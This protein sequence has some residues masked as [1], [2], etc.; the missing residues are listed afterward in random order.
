MALAGLAV[1]ACSDEGGD[2]EDDAS[3]TTAASDPATRST[4]STV[5]TIPTD[6]TVSDDLP[7]DSAAAT[8]AMSVDPNPNN[9]LSAIVVVESDEPVSVMLTAVSGDHTVVV[10]QTA[11]V[12]TSHTIPLVGMRSDRTYEV[13]AELVTSDGEI[14]AGADGS[15]ETGSIPERFERYEFSSDPDRSSP[16]YTLIE[17]QRWVD[18]R[19]ITPQ[20]PFDNPQYLIAVDSAGEIVWYYENGPVIGGVEQTPDGTFTSFYWP[21]GVR[22]FDILGNEVG[23]WQVPSKNA[24][25]PADDESSATVP[26]GTTAAGPGID[27]LDPLPVDSDDVVLKLIHHEAIRLDS[28]NYLALSTASHELTPE[29]RRAFCPDDPTEFN[30][31]SDVAVEFEPSGRVVRT[32]DLWD[33]V[34][35]NV[36]P[37]REMCNEFFAVRNDRDWTHANAVIYDEA[38]D[39]V[40]FSARHTS[41]VVAMR[42]SDAE[43]PQT[44]VLW[45]FGEDGS[46]PLEG[47][48]PQYQHAV[49]IE[50]DGSL[51]LYDN[52]NGRAGTSLD[53]PVNPPFSRAVQYEVDDSSDDPAD[54][55]VRQ[56][57]EHRMDDL[58]GEPLFAPF[59][60]DADRVANG[61]V[62]ITHGGID[63]QN[64]MSYL[65]A[66]VVEVVP[67]DASGGDIVWEFRVGSADRLSSIYR[68]ERIESFYVGAEWV[69]D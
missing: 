64:P 25:D 9:V 22:R 46:V 57:W 2:G 38:R 54:W 3:V 6:D 51:L 8:A 43:G 45:I 24:A 27:A 12:A 66:A 19:S 23:D 33:A 37:G 4:V 1:S 42:H 13:T 34:D 26:S 50:D 7:A 29:Q 18:P 11:A 53:D 14:V 63:F 15:F 67:D 36:T 17:M 60:G 35:I 62:L 69:D 21:N 65:H 40:I 30:A 49:E 48:I 68:A 56:L 47:D 39:A 31:L 58:D 32:W 44:D 20:Q 41:Q 10:P 52:G 61:N 5:S 16:G 59:I 55:V 28:G